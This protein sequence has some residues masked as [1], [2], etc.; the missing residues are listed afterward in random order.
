MF[1][2][3]IG[4]EKI[5]QRLERVIASDNLATA[6]LFIGKK[7]RGKSFVAKEFVQQLFCEKQNVCGS[8]AACLLFKNA[9]HPD[10]FVI[11]Q[12]KNFIEMEQITALVEEVMFSPALAKYR[13]V[14]LKEV[15]NMNKESANAFLKIL[16]EPPASCR[17]ILSTTNEQLLPETIVSRCQRVFFPEF[18]EQELE[19]IILQT[20]NLTKQQV[21]WSIPFHKSGIQKEWF[22]DIQKFF[23]ARGAIWE[24]LSNPSN[25]NFVKLLAFGEKQEKEDSFGACFA[26]FSAFFYDLWLL[27]NG[28]QQEQFFYGY[29]L[30]D[31]TARAV[32]KYEKDKIYRLFQKALTIE[33][34]IKNF[35]NKSLGWCSLI[36]STKQT[37]LTK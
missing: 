13:I 7:G 36:I 35:A 20:T 29:D 33:Q 14:F 17:F 30:K 24:L 16:E 2:S 10:F 26:F 12:R 1:S 4:L 28:T 27:A 37:L 23:D 32:A 6:Y 5:K 19:S 3:V 11:K 22:S 18:S 15:E 21:V 9:N 34:N 25:E 31:L 8:C